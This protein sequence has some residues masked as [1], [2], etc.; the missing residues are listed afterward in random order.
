MKQDRGHDEAASTDTTERSSAAPG[1]RTMTD[2]LPTPVQRAPRTSAPAPLSM[3]APHLGAQVDPFGLHLAAPVQRQGDG[4]GGADVQA[5]ASRGLEAPAQRLPFLDQIQRSFGADHDVSGIQAH[6]GGPAAEASASMGASAYATG[7]HVAFGGS[8]DLH[9]AAHEAAHVV[10][11][12]HGVNLYGG[13]GEAGDRYERNADAVADRVVAGASAADLLPASGG[14]PSTGVQKKGPADDAT[15]G[16]PEP[17]WVKRAREYHRD[18]P[19]FADQFKAATNNACVGADGELDP[20]EIARWQVA[21]GVKPDGICGPDTAHAAANK[22]TPQVTPNAAPVVTDAPLPAPHDP[23]DVDAPPT[24]APTGGPTSEQT[25]NAIKNI[26]T[27]VA[28]AAGDLFNTVID[29]FKGGNT[30]GNTAPK[31]AGGG[32]TPAPAQEPKEE[33]APKPGPIDQGEIGDLSDATLRDIAT[34]SSDPVVKEIAADLAGLVEASHSLRAQGKMNGAE[35]KGKARDTFVANIGVVRGKLASLK[36]EASFKGAAYRL[37]ASIGT[38]YS[39]SR[40]IDILES[41]PPTDT[42]TCNITSLAMALEGL[43]MS[44]ASFKGN[45]DKVQAAAKFYQ[46][47]ITGDATSKAGAVDAVAGQGVSWGQL[48]GMRLSDFLELAAI[49]RSMPDTSDDG[50]KAG[51]KAAWDSI[52]SIS[53]LDHLGSQFGASGSVKAFNAT[54]IKKDKKNKTASDVD[55]LGGFGK[56]HRKDV[57]KYINARNKGEVSSD[58]QAGYDAAMADTSIDDRLSLEA[59]RDYVIEHI[60]ADLAAGGSIV[61]ALTGHYAKLQAIVPDGVIVNDPARDSRA[62]THLTWAEARAMGYFKHRLVL[63]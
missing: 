30:G 51:A 25:L 61:I 50:V 57:E 8:P 4:G 35:E 3:D 14:A 38:Y 43:G 44:A 62:A 32:T 22:V 27:N 2:G 56:D 47:K 31:P 42:R 48:V 45:R 21:H 33:P 5:A 36:G 7:N 23:C 12:A 53:T 11:Q 59:Y 20:N 13:V 1:K 46:H 37:I 18:H 6:V 52:L 24:A 9:T 63:S 58:L 29:A 54:G 16:A 41:P 40:N 34:K 10:Q 26:G 19:K 49:A 17:S 60:G 39:Q 28:D 15:T 55:V